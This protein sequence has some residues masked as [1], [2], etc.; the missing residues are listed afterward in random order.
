MN[1]I[2]APVKMVFTDINKLAKYVP[3][4]ITCCNLFSGC[5]A[6]YAGFD[7]Q[8]LLA[9]LFIL[10]AALFDFCDGFA[11]R[12]LHAYSPIGKDIDSLADIVSFGVAPSSMVFTILYDCL[13]IDWHILSYLAFMIAVFSCL[14]LAKF[15]VDDRQTTSFIGLPVPANA[16]FWASFVYTSNN[17][18]ASI[19][20]ECYIVLIAIFCYLLVSEWPM[21]SLKMK[22]LNW[23]E[24]KIQFIFL[25][26]AAVI[27]IFSRFSPGSLAII[28]AVYI[29]LSIGD[30]LL[31]KP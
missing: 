20:W 19:Y 9:F 10:I 15:N 31:K 1:K 11:A 21:F 2:F 29:L 24:N 16:I 30:Y 3:N 18:F 4:T 28:I 26:T 23:E 22:N 5:I 7:G 6:T 27:V 8:Y 14:R 13:P 12:M 17:L 25:I